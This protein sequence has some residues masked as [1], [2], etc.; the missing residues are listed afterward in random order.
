MELRGAVAVVTGASAGIGRATALAL[1]REG[2]DVVVSARRRD[3]LEDLAGEIGRLGR[4]A[5]VVPCDVGERDHVDALARATRGEFGRVDVLVN[6]AGI[7][8]GGRFE[9]ISVEQAERVIRVNYLGVVYATKAF[10]PMMLEARRGHV[11]NVASLA[12][13]FALPGSAVYSSTKHAVVAFSEALY[14]ELGQ[15]G[16]VVTA[17]NPGLVA[18]AGFPHDDARERRVGRVMRPE[19]IAE[20]IVRVVRTGKGPEVS[21]PRWLAAMQA[22]RVLAPPAYRFGMRRAAGGTLRPTDMRSEPSG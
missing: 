16:I 18:T 4:R 21:K 10:L 19:E 2:A 3:M 1:A 7:P 20:L 22:V 15:K 5:L 8:G 17:V 6:N 12:G 11:V 13:R 14:F 9:S